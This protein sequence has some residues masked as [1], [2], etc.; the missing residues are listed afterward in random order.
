[1]GT[2]TAASFDSYPPYELG[3]AAC[4]DVNLYLNNWGNTDNTLQVDVYFGA[5]TKGL[6]PKNANINWVKETALTQ[7]FN[8]SGGTTTIIPAIIT[9]PRMKSS[10]MKLTFTLTGTT[11]TVDVNAWFYG[12]SSAAATDVSG[13]ALEAGGNLATVVAR[14]PALGSAVSASSS[15]VVIA[16]DQA[17][18]PI[19]GA[20]THNNAAPTTDNIGVLPALANASS[21]TFVEGDQ[22]L[23]SVNLSGNMRS[24][25]NQINGQAVLTGNGVTGTGSLRVTLASDTTANSN[26]FL[27]VI[28]DA[29]GNARGANVTASNELVVSD[30][31][32]RPASTSLNTYSVHLTSNATT[33]PTSSTAYISSVTISNEV[34]GTTSTITIQDKQGT[35][36]KL[37]N[38]V[39]TTAL[40]TAPTVV[41]F[42][43]PVKMVSGIDII[44]AGAVAATVDVWINYYQ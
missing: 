33:T 2:F 42:Q 16:S 40:T 3:W 7:T 15:P 29:A 19:K 14:T 24:T 27:Q 39:A 28:R 22:V 43:T 1:M 18:F 4:G 30:S 36:L 21:P 17:A 25:V 32:L 13:L 5:M 44:T 12:K 20:K 8:A 37:I 6:F 23:A 31:G 9:I 11:K 41:N 38:G 35:P 26:P 10:F 34:G